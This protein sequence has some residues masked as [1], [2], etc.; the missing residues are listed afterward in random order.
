MESQTGMCKGC[1]L[2][3]SGGFDGA[4]R[5]ILFFFG[6]DRILFYTLCLQQVAGAHFYIRTYLLIRCM[7]ILT[8]FC[9]PVAN[10][11]VNHV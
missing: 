1:I 2:Y 4:E 5:D 3:S 10:K 11:H 6:N 7:P 8:M 9:S